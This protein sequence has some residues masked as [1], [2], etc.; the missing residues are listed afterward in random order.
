M[1]LINLSQKLLVGRII[2]IY[3]CIL[4]KALTPSYF[5]V[6]TILL[7]YDFVYFRFIKLKMSKFVNLYLKPILTTIKPIW[8]LK[9]FHLDPIAN[10]FNVCFTF[11]FVC[12]LIKMFSTNGRFLA[13]EF[14][15]KLYL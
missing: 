1:A 11:L 13:N 15:K 8:I 6:Q 14:S 2:S 7:G 10:G 4:I 3:S 12:V 5:C 9:Y